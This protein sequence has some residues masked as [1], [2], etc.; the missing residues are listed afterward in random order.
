MHEE[1]ALT[2]HSGIFGQKDS[3]SAGHLFMIISDILLTDT[4]AIVRQRKGLRWRRLQRN[5]LV[6]KIRLPYRL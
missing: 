6:K 1:S 4:M 3:R 2:P 5:P